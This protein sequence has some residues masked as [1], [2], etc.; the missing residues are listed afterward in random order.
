MCCVR[1]AQSC[2]RLFAIPW[3]VARQAPLPMGFFRQEYWTALPFSSPGD[4][5]DPGI[6]ARSPASQAD[7]LPIEPLASA[8]PQ[9]SSRPLAHCPWSQPGTLSG[10]EDPPHW[11]LTSHVLQ[12]SRFSYHFQTWIKFYVRAWNLA[13]QVIISEVGWHNSEP[14]INSPQGDLW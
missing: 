13:F 4:L 8:P 5:S 6:K 2:L 14:W 11:L 7:S 10:T 9:F 3:T 1:F 12:V